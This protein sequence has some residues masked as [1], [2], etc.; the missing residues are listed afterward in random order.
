[1]NRYWLR[2]FLLEWKRLLH[3]RPAQLT[4]LVSA[5]SPLAGLFLW[6]S[7]SADTMLSRYLADPAIAAGTAGGIAFGV[8]TILE[9]DRPSSS[10]AGLLTDSVVPPHT[11]ALVRLPAFFWLRRSSQV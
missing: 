7:T 8:L 5:A 1:M 6:C 4:L 9:L 10:R 2:L 11:M 3:S